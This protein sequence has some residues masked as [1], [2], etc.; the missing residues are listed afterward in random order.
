MFELITDRLLLKPIRHENAKDVERVIF[1]DPEVVKGLAHDGSDPNVRRT[2]STEWSSFGPDG[3]KDFWEECKIGLYVITDRSGILAPLS[4]FMGV[5]GVYLEKKNEKWAGEL[6][7]A[8]GSSYH[9]KGVMSEACSSVVSHFKSIAAADSLY[10]LYWQLLNPASGSIL[11][12]LGFEKDGTQSIIEEYDEE[13]VTGIRNFELWRLSNSRSDN[14][15]RIAEEVAIKLGHFEIE[16][17]SSKSE[18]LRDIFD[19]ISDKNLVKEL[20]GLV[21]GALEIGRNTPG[22]AMMR[23]H[24]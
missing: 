2:H 5:T 1:D 18:N 12:K 20:G 10:A 3:N 19:A 16:G 7:Y 15:R 23:F 8:L 9:G 14:I 24:V 17:I 22:F 6:F 11:N 13:T 21:E 4:E